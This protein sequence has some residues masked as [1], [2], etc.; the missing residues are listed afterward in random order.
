MGCYCSDSISKI[1]INLLQLSSETRVR[2]FKLWMKKCYLDCKICVSWFIHKKKRSMVFLGGVVQ[3][4]FLVSSCYRS[5]I[6]R[7]TIRLQITHYPAAPFVGHLHFP[8]HVIFHGHVLNW[9]P[10]YD[11]S[12]I[13]TWRRKKKNYSFS[14]RLKE[15]HKQRYLLPP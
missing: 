7:H 3:L 13:V 10:E 12:T 2:P 15:V 11:A 8:D 1:K 6:D 14:Y 9:I 5:N 4:A